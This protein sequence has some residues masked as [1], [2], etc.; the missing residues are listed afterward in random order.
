MNARGARG[1]GGVLAKDH[2]VINEPWHK[3][4]MIADFQSQ[5]H[6]A[7]QHIHRSYRLIMVLLCRQTP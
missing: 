1:C 5:L 2:S 6:E 7:I 3:M 4:H